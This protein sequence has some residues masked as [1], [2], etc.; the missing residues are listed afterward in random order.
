MSRDTFGLDDEL[1]AYIRESTL[2]EGDLKRELR[3]ETGELEAAQMQISPEQGQFMGLLVEI[4]G[5]RRAIEIGTFTGYSAICVAEALPEDGELIACDVD[6]EWTDIA[7]DYWRR[8]GLEERI[9]LR[10][11]PALETTRE[12]LEAGQ[13][14]TFDFA[15]I[16]ADKENY[17]VYYEETLELLRPGGLMAVDN[18]LWSGSV[19]DE[20]RTDETTESIRELNE[21][22]GSDERVSMALVPIGD[23][24]NLARK[25]P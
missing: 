9:E 4:L 22:M 7:R 15:F 12:L 19:A 11:Q 20:E 3:E 8:A 5:A 18:T 14:G 6:E 13:A 21:K 16:D 23:G 10:L 17:P 25:R 24:V 1:L 2:R